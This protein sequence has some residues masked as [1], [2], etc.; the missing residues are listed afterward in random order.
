MVAKSKKAEEDEVRL[1]LK[2]VELGFKP[3]E[4]GGQPSAKNGDGSTAQAR[5]PLV[6]SAA[7]IRGVLANGSCQSAVQSETTSRLPY[8]RLTGS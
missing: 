6:S 2:P 7:V 3:I 8:V 5:L 4:S 1:E